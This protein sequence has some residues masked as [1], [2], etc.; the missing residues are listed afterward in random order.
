MTLDDV[1]CTDGGSSGMEIGW[2]IGVL[3]DAG[4]GGNEVIIRRDGKAA[5]V[6][7]GWLQ[8]LKD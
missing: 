2:L 5:A 8:V 6:R 1:I 3:A 7:E 4:T